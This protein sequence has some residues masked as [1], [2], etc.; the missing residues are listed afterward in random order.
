MNKILAIAIDEYSSTQIKNLKNCLND[1]NSIVNILTTE[2]E[3]DSNNSEIILYTKPEQTTLSYLYSKLNEEFYNSLDND[4][5]LVIFAGHGEYNDYLKTGY[6]LCSDSKHDDPTTWFDINILISFFANSKAKHIALIS[7]SCFSGSIFHRTRG[8]GLEA[9]MNKKSRQALT[10][11]GLEE[12]SDGNENENSPFNKAIQL[13][14]RENESEILT[15]TAFSETTIKHFPYNRKQTPEYGSLNIKGD[16]GGTYIFKRKINTSSN[17]ITFKN[18]LLPLEIDKRIKINC[19]INIP[20]FSGNTN[21]DLNFINIFVQQLGYK[22]INDIRAFSSIDLDYLIERSSQYTFEVESN[23][24]IDR[25]DKENLSISF[26]H[27]DDFA[28][29]HPN[30]YNYSINFKLNPTR[31]V[32]IFDVFDI[33][34]NDGLTNLIVKFAEEECKDILLHILNTIDKYSLDFSFNDHTLFLYFTN[35]L[36]H[37]YK[38]C[39]IVQIPLENVSFRTA[40]E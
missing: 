4:S 33:D 40:I 24:N 36:V 34:Y 16:S 31:K 13:T 2:Y 10:S 32:N 37:A 5:F 1:I 8:G 17:E 15:F 7:D 28:T 30:Y 26:Y 39:G 12:V 22:I 35:H 21:I 19:N 18:M 27:S 9:L 11:G 25:L 3:Y 20:F 6:W 23:Y 14:L 29:L 38:A